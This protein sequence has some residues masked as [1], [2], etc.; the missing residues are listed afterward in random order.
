MSDVAGI[1]DNLGTLST[2]GGGSSTGVDP[3]QTL[4]VRHVAALKLTVGHTHSHP[5]EVQRRRAHHG[6]PR[7]RRLR[8]GARLNTVR[9]HP[10]G[11]PSCNQPAGSPSGA[12]DGAPVHYGH[13]RH[14]Q[15]ALYRLEQKHV[16]TCWQA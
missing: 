15:T 11:N 6:E 16:A 9:T 14:E 7:S 4:A 10:T 1:G 5:L 2:P 3:E 12:P 8:Q 13:Y